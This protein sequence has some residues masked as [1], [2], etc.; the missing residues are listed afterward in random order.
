[1]EDSQSFDIGQPMNSTAANCWL[2]ATAEFVSGDN[3]L[4]VRLSIAQS[5]LGKLM[6]GPYHVPALQAVDIVLAHRQSLIP[7]A[8]TRTSGVGGDSSQ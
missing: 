7:L 4:A 6:V 8:A 3:Q 5:L 2:Q 1:M